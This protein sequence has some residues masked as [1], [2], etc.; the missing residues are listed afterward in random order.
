VLLLISPWYL[1][2]T[3]SL[4]QWRVTQDWV[5]WEPNGYRREIVLRD[6]LIRY[7]SGAGRSLWEKHRMAEIVAL[8]V[9][10]TAALLTL[11]RRRTETVKGIPLLLIIWFVLAAAGPWVADIARGTFIAEYPRYGSAAMPAACLLGAWA[12]GNAGPRLALVGLVGIACCWAPSVASI[13][14]SRSRGGQA[15]RDVA[16]HIGPRSAE[17]LILVHSIP[18]G[19][20]LLARYLTTDAAFAVWTA[21]LGQRKIPDSITSLIRGRRSVLLVKLHTVGEPA[22]E[23]TW[24]KEHAQA[25]K[26]KQLGDVFIDEYRPIGNETFR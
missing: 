21:Q 14:R 11:W 10:G 4:A 7:F 9:F 13:Y 22:P 12:L 24:L 20:I 8:V 18:S 15:I 19:A 6:S 25:T 2:V 23:E 26:T 5:K 17:D 1:H 3:E 16:R